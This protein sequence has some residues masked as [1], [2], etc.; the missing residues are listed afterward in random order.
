MA[1]RSGRTRSS[2]ALLLLLAL[3]CGACRNAET[4]ADAYRKAR[5]D[6]DQND[7]SAAS[8]KV[9]AAL[10]HFTNEDDEWVW[11]LR[12][13]RGEILAKNHRVADSLAILESPL[14][15]RF[16]DREVAVRRLLALGIANRDPD[17]F[18]EAHALALRSQPQLLVDTHLA[19]AAL[20]PISE[21]ETHLHAAIDLARAQ[22]KEI[23][24]ANAYNALTRA[25]TTAGRYGEA[26]DAGEE[27]LRRY[28]QL[29][30]HGRVSAAAGNLGWAYTLIGDYETAEALFAQA[31]KAAR[32][33]GLTPERM[34][35]INQLGNVK[36][37]EGNFAE[38]DRYYAEA[39]ELAARDPEMT[40]EDAQ[41]A[42]NRAR[43]ALAL[44]RVEVADQLN[45]R[46][47]AIKR[48]LSD[49]AAKTIE[50]ELISQIIQARIEAARGQIG[51]AEQTLRDV[52]ARS[53]S[54]P[55]QW[56]AQ[57]R[58]AGL[59]VDAHRDDRA[60]QEFQRAIETAARA[61]AAVDPS[62]RELRLSFFNLVAQVFDAYIDFL[63][64]A[65]RAEDALAVT[66]LSRAQT[67]QEGLGIATSSTRLNAR[68]IARERNATILCY[69]LGRSRAYLWIVTPESVSVRTL[70][71][72]H[73]IESEVIAYR[74]DLL[75]L[76]G[77]LQASGARGRALYQTLVAPAGPLAKDARVIVI[78]DGDLHAI[79][80]ETLVNGDHYW[81]EDV[82]LSDASSLQLL[83]HAG[84]PRVS[85]DS[86]LLVGNA[87]AVDAYP[88]LRQAW[89]EIA[90]IKQ[91][92]ENYIA[93]NE[94]AA[95]PSA[96]RDVH[97]QRFEYVH[98]VAHGIASRKRPLE[99]A[100]ILAREAN[101][102]KLFARDI[103]EERLNAR[104]VTISSCH[105][106]GTR[107]YAG[108]GLVGLAWAFL[109]AGSENVIGALWE[110]NDT[111]TPKLM[112]QMYVALRAGRDPAIALRDAKLPLVRAEG[113][114]RKPVY[115]A[116]FVLYSGS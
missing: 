41:Y 88:K 7:L 31:T 59:Y 83:A 112:E 65:G 91:H 86:I 45:T 97:P 70:P 82:V 19:L 102:Y 87:P 50:S 22:H 93:L 110:V 14:P 72:A 61:R 1:R 73:T 66:E 15:A 77:T 33:A 24:V 6:S 5:T 89:S 52:A 29:G 2:I 12:M 85:N 94:R 107:T 32:E 78:A 69:W 100:I 57:A 103:L 81:I 49:D 27:A 62:N 40:E 3:L 84:T 38:A 43:A 99:S 18:A 30:V 51:R 116:P 76:H 95:T 55:T 34:K 58:L 48:R 104:L 13:L 16:A 21:A 90:G 101:G 75:G 114:Q 37:D 39:L 98:F 60:E 79:N 44:N 74:R 106:A 46:A 63:V 111:A 9:D 71:P 8:A 25:Y 92:F 67:L 53:S 96:Y 11:A 109:A 105:G 80:F 10:A 20:S 17:R 4:A 28:D 54:L 26:I 56:E 108:E 115:W 23:A 113:V 47:L 35:W 42:A 36:F 64:D 68:A